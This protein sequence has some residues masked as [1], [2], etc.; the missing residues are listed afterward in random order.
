M[1]KQPFVPMTSENVKEFEIRILD[2]ND[3]VVCIVMA[4][5]PWTVTAE[6]YRISQRIQ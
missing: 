6:E 2:S 1:R 4:H 5:A 3:L